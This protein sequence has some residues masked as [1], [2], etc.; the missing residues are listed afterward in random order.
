MHERHD[1]RL[2]RGVSSDVA[3]L[4][5]D[6]QECTSSEVEVEQTAVV[7]KKQRTDLLAMHTGEIV[8]WGEVHNMKFMLSD[9]ASIILAMVTHKVCNRIRTLGSTSYYIIMYSVMPGTRAM[10]EAS[11]NTSPP[12]VLLQIVMQH[13]LRVFAFGLP[14]HV[15]A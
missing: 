3:W 5:A 15:L 14:P 7:Y 2:L 12:R 9:G 1:A 6:P 13:S 8:G 11:P 4:I 10:T